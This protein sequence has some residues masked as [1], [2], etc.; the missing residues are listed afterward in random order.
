MIFP[1][2]GKHLLG[3]FPSP[4]AL[5]GMSRWGICVVNLCVHVHYTWPEAVP[6]SCW[7][8]RIKSGVKEGPSRARNEQ[9]AH[10]WAECMFVRKGGVAPLLCL[11]SRDHRSW[12][13]DLRV[14]RNLCCYRECAGCVVFLGPVLLYLVTIPVQRSFAVCFEKCPTHDLR[15][16]WDFPVGIL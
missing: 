15:I 4:I 6:A 9:L 8:L 3:G 13:W 16:P 14:P 1:S 2:C 10:F 7:V 11:S 5:S 12:K